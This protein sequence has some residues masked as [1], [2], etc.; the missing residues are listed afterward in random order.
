MALGL[1]AQHTVELEAMST[2]EFG[3]EGVDRALRL[4]GGDWEDDAIHVTVAPWS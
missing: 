1:M 4:V 3:L 2:H